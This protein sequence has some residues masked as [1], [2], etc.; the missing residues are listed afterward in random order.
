MRLDR[1]K[2][3][4]RVQGIYGRLVAGGYSL[5]HIQELRKA[6]KDFRDS[7]KFAY[8]YSSSYGEA[9]GFRKLL[10]CNGF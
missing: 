8:I 10:P 3:D 9:G 7:G 2:D 6:I 4:P 5:A 1:A